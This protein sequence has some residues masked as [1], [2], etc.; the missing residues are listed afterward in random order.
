[1]EKVGLNIAQKEFKQLSKC[2][3]NVYNTVVVIDFFIA[4]QPNLI[5]YFSSNCISS[6]VKPYFL[7]A[8]N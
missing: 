3:G 8:A 1:M 4:S 7:S 5:G 2:A 6:I